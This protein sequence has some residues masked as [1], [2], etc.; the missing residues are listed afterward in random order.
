MMNVDDSIT[1]AVNALS[2][3]ESKAQEH[4][5]KAKLR[6][7]MDVKPKPRTKTSDMGH[8]TPV[9]APSSEVS[10]LRKIIEEFVLMG[11][12]A[13]TEAKNTREE[14]ERFMENMHQQ[15]H[16]LDNQ[17][18]D[19]QNGEIQN[20]GASHTWSGD[21]EEHKNNWEEEEEEGCISTTRQ[22]GVLRSGMAKS[23][24]ETF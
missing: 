18:G 12:E 24:A 3:S 5:Q 7:K 19:F 17:N 9:P 16:V 2:E 11:E 14:T 21:E 4:S 10:E 8:Q 13:R 6:K 1:I 20:G 23:T 15:V 22:L